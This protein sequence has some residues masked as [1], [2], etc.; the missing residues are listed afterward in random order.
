MLTVRTD[1][2]CGDQSNL[3]HQVEHLDAKTPKDETTGFQTSFQQNSQTRA[4][5]K[6]HW[7]TNAR[8]HQTVNITCP[9][10]TR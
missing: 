1:T 10:T 3:K 7:L 4:R 5:Q 2:T 6:R 9:V 8:W